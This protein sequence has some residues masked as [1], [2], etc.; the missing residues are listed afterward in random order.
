MLTSE[1]KSNRFEFNLIESVHAPEYLTIQHQTPL[2]PAYKFEVDLEAAYFTEEKYDHGPML[3]S[4][5]TLTFLVPFA[6]S[7]LYH[8]SD[9]WRLFSGMRCMKTINEMSMA[10]LVRLL[11]GPGS[12]AFYAHR[13]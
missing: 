11:V 6:T 4:G 13:L 3:V 8:A 7:F 1:K 10:S 2:E 5:P 12:S 9:V